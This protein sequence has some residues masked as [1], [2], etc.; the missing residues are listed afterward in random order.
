[1]SA[2]E[3]RTRTGVGVAAALV[4]VAIWATWMLG[5]RATVS[6]DAGVDPAAASFIRYVTT[7]ILLA[8]W[9]IRTG[10]LPRG[11]SAWTLVGLLFAGAPYIWLVGWGLRHTPAAEAGPLLSGTLPL[12]VAVLAIV[13]L[14]ERL[15]ASQLAGLAFIAAGVAVIVGSAIHAG[16]GSAGWGHLI[17]LAS[18]VVWAIY[19]I[20]FRRSGLD[21]L[22]AAGVISLWSLLM[23]AP[24]VSSVIW[25][26]LLE[27]T[28]ADIAFQVLIQGV[29]GGIVAMATYGSAVQH[30]G[31][32]RASAITA[33]T[34]AVG[35]IAAI[36]LLGERPGVFAIAGCAATVVGVLLASGSLVRQAA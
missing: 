27:M 28:H 2:T 1:M 9:W 8:P 22:S 4:T 3:T 32:A 7:C 12:F 26:A 30:L 20:A 11:I 36:P 33:A 13:F 17:M 31:A 34:P 5:T 15:R 24:F 6:G 19:T 29:L 21:A 23:L 16:N 18:A 35:L 25:P 10:P 14:R